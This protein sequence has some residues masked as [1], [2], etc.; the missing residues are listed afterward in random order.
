[1][2]MSSNQQ[3][4]I[5]IKISSYISRYLNLI[6]ERPIILNFNIVIIIIIIIIQ[7]IPITCSSKEKKHYL[8]YGIAMMR[9]NSPRPLVEW[10]QAIDIN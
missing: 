4:S 5:G 10:C 2:S 9:H 7:K 6:R 3:K 8:N 1:M